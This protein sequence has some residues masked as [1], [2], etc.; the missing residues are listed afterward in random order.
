MFGTYVAN[1]LGEME[2]ME[3]YLTIGHAVMGLLE[4]WNEE[5]FGEQY[6]EVRDRDELTMAS[7]WRPRPDSDPELALVVYYGTNKPARAFRCKYVLDSD[8]RRI[9]TSIVEVDA[10]SEAVAA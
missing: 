1:D 6:F 3:S 9:R 7:V 8:D 4:L 2:A 10:H 5:E